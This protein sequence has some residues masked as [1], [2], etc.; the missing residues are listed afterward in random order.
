MN[1]A[2]IAYNKKKV[3]RFEVKSFE[4]NPHKVKLSQS[5]SENRENEG[6]LNQKLQKSI[7]RLKTHI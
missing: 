3:N 2:F 4:K 7:E 6:N 1:H 5:I